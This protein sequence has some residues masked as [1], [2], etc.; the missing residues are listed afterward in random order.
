MIFRILVLIIT[1]LLAFVIGLDAKVKLLNLDSAISYPIIALVIG[2]LFIGLE[3]SAHQA[4]GR[5]LLYA[6]LGMLIGIAIGWFFG[7]IFVISLPKIS[8][9]F[10]YIIMLLLAYVGF[11]LGWLKE[12]ELKVTYTSPSGMPTEV[13]MTHKILDTSVIIDGRIADIAETGFLEGVL[14]VP[15]FVLNELH[16]VADSSDP[17]KRSRG[18]RGLDILNNMK[19]SKTTVIK[20]T[21]EDFLD[22]PEVDS[23]LLKLAIQ[24]VNAVI[25]TND[26]NLN[27]VAE[28]QGVAIL[29]INELANAVK[30]VLLPNEEI[31]ITVIKEG[32]D[33]NQGIAYLDDGTMI[34]IDNGRHY[35]GKEVNVV[36]TSILQTPAGRMIF[37]QINDGRR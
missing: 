36:V 3:V 22:T 25:V 33:Q 19:A 18:R 7:E 20:I 26:F 1:A 11:T 17:L 27:K 2:G 12:E 5:K 30:P 8:K 35:I 15:K 21:E 13:K 28:F 34:V 32:K 9:E 29:N 23:K 37:T 6:S 14:I 31:R 16:Q 10:K 24:Y 4:K